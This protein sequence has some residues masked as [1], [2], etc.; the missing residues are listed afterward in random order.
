MN[1]RTMLLGGAAGVAAL[2]GASL[3][4]LRAGTVAPAGATGTRTAFEVVRTEEE[5][6]QLL[7]P[8]AYRVLRQHGTESAGSSPLDTA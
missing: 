5:W 3:L 7:S 8:A 6:R 4:G 2:G 1:R